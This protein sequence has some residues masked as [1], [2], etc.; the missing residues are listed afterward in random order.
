MLSACINHW[1][2]D[3]GLSKLFDNVINNFQF[4]VGSKLDKEYKDALTNTLYFVIEGYPSETIL[5]SDYVLIINCVKKV[6]LVSPEGEKYLL[7]VLS[8]IRL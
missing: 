1:I 8:N 4:D 6:H 7:D 3:I 5:S 2:M